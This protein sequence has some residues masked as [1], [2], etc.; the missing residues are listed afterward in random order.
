MVIPILDQHTHPWLE[1][2]QSGF[3]VKEMSVDLEK[4]EVRAPD[5]MS[6]G[7]VRL[8]CCRT[9]GVWWS[10]GH[11]A[12]DDARRDEGS[13]PDELVECWGS[14][15]WRSDEAFLERADWAR[16]RWSH[17]ESRHDPE[18]LPRTVASGRISLDNPVLEAR[19]TRG[20]TSCNWK[21]AVLRHRYPVS[22][23]ESCDSKSRFDGTNVESCA[24]A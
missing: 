9:T 8:V 16:K 22:R 11:A 12:C 10:V 2:E 17:L 21:R 15:F 18:D 1:H 23:S 6:L 24:V 4:Q 20:L 14:H 13:Q 3:F 7:N 5:I 19:M